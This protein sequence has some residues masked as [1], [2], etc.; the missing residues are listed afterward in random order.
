MT[1]SSLRTPHRE[2]RSIVELE[3]NNSAGAAEGRARCGKS[4]AHNLV[5]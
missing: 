3:P 4:M 1:R 2:R 5:P